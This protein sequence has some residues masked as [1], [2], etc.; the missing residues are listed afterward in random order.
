MMRQVAINGMVAMESVRAKMYAR[1][2]LG[3]LVQRD[4]QVREDLHG[5][6]DQQEVTRS[7]C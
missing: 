4:V 1:H 6:Q 2:L 5:Q 3:N 7:D